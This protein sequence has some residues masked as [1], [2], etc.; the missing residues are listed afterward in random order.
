MAESYNT[1]DHLLDQLSSEEVSPTQTA[2]VGM[3]NGG[4]STID[5]VFLSLH[6][7]IAKAWLRKT[8]TSMR[9]FLEHVVLLLAGVCVCVCVC[10]CV[11]PYC[12]SNKCIKQWI[13]FTFP[14]HKC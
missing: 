1:L 5:Q 4:S 10:V 12:F 6:C 9:S 7:K 2:A 8:S 13:F 14:L 3:G 11:F